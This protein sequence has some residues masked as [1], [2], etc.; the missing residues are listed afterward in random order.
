MPGIKKIKTKFDYKDYDLLV[1][2]DLISY[3]RISPFADTQKKYFDTHTLIAIDHH[4]DTAPL[5]ALTIH[6]TQVMSCAELIFEYAEKRRKKYIDKEVATALYL[7]LTMDS[8]NFLF[9]E[10]HERTFT[11]ALGLIKL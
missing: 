4:L 7:G 11:N 10:D 9:D 3:Q 6:D 5:H 2:V 8:G 1:F